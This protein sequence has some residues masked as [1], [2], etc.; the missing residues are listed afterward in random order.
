MSKG[1]DQYPRLIQAVMQAWT[2]QDF[3]AAEQAARA[4]LALRA[5]D[6]DAH[7]ILGVLALQRGYPARAYQHLQRAANAAP[8]QPQIFNLLGVAARQ[9]D[10]LEQ[11]RA[12]FSRAGALGLSDGWRNLGELASAEGR[13]SEALAAFE[14]AVAL[15]PNSVPAN[16]ALALAL[17]RRHDLARAKT[18]AERALRADTNSQTA[19]LALGQ[20]A[21]RER[22]FAG[23][24]AVL[25]GLVE[26]PR[27]TAANRAIALG[28]IGE[29][30]D[31]EGAPDDAFAAF[32]AANQALLS[33]YGPYRD[34]TAS[35]FHPAAV[36]RLRALV[37]SGAIAAADGAVA[38]APV[39]LVGFPR[40]GTTLLDQVLAS[41]P[42]IVALEERDIFAPAMADFIVSDAGV[43]A[44]PGAGADVLAAR[45]AQYW[46]AADA[47]LGAPRGGRLLL[48]K[49]PLNIIFLPLIARVFPGAKIIVALRDPR[50][51]ILSCYQQRFGMNPAMAQLLELETAA[52]YYDAVMGHYL[53]CRERLG[54]ALHEVRYEDVVADLEGAA[55]KLAQFL[56]LRFE[57]AMLDFTATAKKRDI[58]TP[59]ARQ[60]IEPLYTRSIG[61]W[62][63]YAQHLAPALPVL[64]AWASRFGYQ[65]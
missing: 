37:E 48:D 57:P 23:A 30:H 27:A 54:L 62:R 46:R 41:H 36:A 60:V 15:A 12:A 63:G 35:P 31:R 59:S 16:A 9:L 34:M 47:A 29:A 17:E 40:S 11:A 4:V 32:T 55:R 21:L 38:E 44:L 14:K 1:A 52:R 28:L 64:N 51:V 53:S 2:R 13:V 58:G 8:S 6:P 3:P 65:A 20:I 10:D 22:D 49:L 33:V 61:R 26:N 56:S 19:R 7:Q 5:E 43:A 45:R 42:H 18:H 24:R 50:D 25:S 39:F